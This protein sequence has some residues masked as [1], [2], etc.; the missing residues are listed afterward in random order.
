[1]KSLHILYLSALV[2][3]FASCK[4]EEAPALVNSWKLIE[5]LSD[6]GDGSGTFQ[7]V[8]SSKTVSFFDDG[9]VGSNGI[10]CQMSSG[11]GT[12]SAGTYSETEKVITPENCG[13]APFLIHYEMEGANLILNYPCIE[14]CREKYA[15]VE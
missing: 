10:L 1:M 11:S 14:A 9:T 12:G 3:L 8:T 2:F 13:V 15:V 7:P 4:K 5:V 6:P